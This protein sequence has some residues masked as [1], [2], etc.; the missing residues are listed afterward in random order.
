M[1]SMRTV[2]VIGV[3]AFS[4]CGAARPA[5]ETSS[6][7]SWAL[8]SSWPADLNKIGAM[9]GTSGVDVD[10]VR[11]EVYMCQQRGSPRVSVWDSKTGKLLRTWGD[12]VLDTPH[13]LRL[14]PSSI[15]T[16]DVEV[17]IMDMGVGVPD[18]GNVIRVFSSDGKLLRTIGTPG[19]EGT[20]LDPVQF[21]H[22]ADMDWSTNEKVIVAVD[23]DGGLNNRVVAMDAVT[24]KVVKSWG[25]LGTANGAFDI[26]HGIAIDVC[27]RV[28]VADRKNNRTQVFT[29]D[30]EWL[31][32]W[33]C[34]NEPPY[35]LRM[36]GASKSSVCLCPVSRVPC[37]NTTLV[38]G[39]QCGV[40]VSVCRLQQYASALLQD[41]TDRNASPNGNTILNTDVHSL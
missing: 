29:L 36:F 28:W 1:T 13:G 11:G 18:T 8:D 16:G 14:K 26:P 23:G 27:D 17:W 10:P 38:S 31:A 33:T 3:L 7:D 35:G 41:N 5:V 30:G 2:V 37:G 24:S 6:R 40:H 15:T 9:N 22:V 32:T 12:D 25:K 39:S 20:G 19:S 34:M 21:S 4:Q